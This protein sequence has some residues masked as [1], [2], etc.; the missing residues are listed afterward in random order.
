M[1]PLVA[2]LELPTIE[3]D[4]FK[5]CIIEEEMKLPHEVSVE[6]GIVLIPH[7]ID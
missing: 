1:L 7:P 4:F 3:M 5:A 6:P 2:P